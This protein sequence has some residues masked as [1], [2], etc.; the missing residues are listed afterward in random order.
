M[1]ATAAQTTTTV[2]QL[3][4]LFKEIYGDKLENLIPDAK[5]FTKMIGFKEKDKEGNKYNQ[6]VV[7][8]QE[9]GITQ[10]SDAAGAFNLMDPVAMVI[11]NAEVNGYQ[12]LGRSAI[13]Y[14]VAFKGSNKKKAFLESTLLI[15]ESLKES[16]TRRLEFNMLYGQSGLGNAVDISDYSSD[17]AIIQISDATWATGLWMGQENAYIN[18]YTDSALVGTAGASGALGTADFKIT[19][20]DTENKRI[21]IEGDSTALSTLNTN[22]ND[23]TKTT[24]IYYK[25]T[26]GNEMAGLDKIMTNS[27]SLFGISAAAYN[28]WKANSYAVGGNLT[29]PK[30]YKAIAKSI[31]KGLDKNAVALVNPNAW[32]FLLDDLA[33]NRRYDSSYKREKGEEGFESICLY[34][35]SGKI[36]VYGYNM[37]K[38]GDGFIFPKNRLKR[39]GA[40]D[41]TF[42]NPYTN[43][44]YFRELTNKAGFEV[45]CY[46]HQGLFCETPARLTKMTGI[47]VT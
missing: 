40:T 32:A 42:K 28:L 14:D 1:A 37:V 3:E 39:I 18:F 34:T 25:D 22:L 31:N 13:P 8:T 24:V 4:G 33:A 35:Q 9:H 6:P 2:A 20:V 16:I 45:R 5:M 17:E 47:T 23:S 38:Q 12:I 36:D 21:T 27:G 43:N 7:L 26:N 46:T 19:K 10:A 29:A 15:I 41:I 30:F 44:E 11:K